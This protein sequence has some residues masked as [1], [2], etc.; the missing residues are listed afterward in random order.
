MENYF[1]CRQCRKCKATIP[2]LLPLSSAPPHL[3]IELLKLLQV[4]DARGTVFEEAFVPLLELCFI[5]F[6]VLG[7]IIQDLRGQLAVVFPHDTSPLWGGGDN[8]EKETG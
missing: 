5:E 8:T 4:E 2:L 3:N 7:Q 1:N 6:S